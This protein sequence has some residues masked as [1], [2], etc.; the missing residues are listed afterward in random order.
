MMSDLSFSGKQSQQ[1]K[2]EH[3]LDSTSTTKDNDQLTTGRQTVFLGY[4]TV[5][6]H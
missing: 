3:D 1:Q 2:E 6:L 4:T 5:F